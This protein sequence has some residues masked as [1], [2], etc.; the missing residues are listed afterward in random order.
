[1]NKNIIIVGAG[2]TGLSA[3]INL[4]RNG[5]TLVGVW[6]YN[7]KLIDDLIKIAIRSKDKLN[8]LITHKF[9]IEDIH[10]AFYLQLTRNCGKVVIKP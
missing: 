3:G 4:I 2:I 7:Y 5:L 8:T 1:M 6:H 9:K 10:E